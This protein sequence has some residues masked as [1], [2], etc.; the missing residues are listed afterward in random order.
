MDTFKTSSG[1]EYQCPYLSTNPMMGIM[2]ISVSGMTWAEAAGLFGDANEM[3]D[4]EFCGQ[5]II[6][7][8]RVDWIKQ[9]SYG[10]K[11]QMSIPR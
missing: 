8:T 9:E 3:K 7:H 2:F 10:L 4:I 5:H 1:K 6:G 11:A